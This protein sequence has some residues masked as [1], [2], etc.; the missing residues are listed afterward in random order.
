MG[1]QRVGHDLATEQQKGSSI[2]AFKE[3]HTVFHNHYQHSL[4]VDFLMMAILTG[5]R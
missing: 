5:V 4:F 3:L 2:P 1:L